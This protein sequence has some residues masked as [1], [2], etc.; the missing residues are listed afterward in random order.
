METAAAN[1]ATVRVRGQLAGARPDPGHQAQRCGRS[2]VRLRPRQRGVRRPEPTT[3][4]RSRGW[5]WATEHGAPAGPAETTRRRLYQDGGGARRGPW[6][7]SGPPRRRPG[8]E[9]VH[10]H[11]TAARCVRRRAAIAADGQ[12]P[13]GAEAQERDGEAESSTPWRWASHS[14]V[15][16]V[17]GR[18]RPRSAN[19]RQARPPCRRTRRC[20][21]TVLLDPGASA[22]P[23]SA[24]QP[25]PRS[26][27]SSARRRGHLL[28]K[29]GS[30]PKTGSAAF[31]RRRRPAHLACVSGSRPGSRS[32]RTGQEGQPDAALEGQLAAPPSRVVEHLLHVDARCRLVASG[33][34]RTASASLSAVELDEL[35]RSSVT[36]SDARRS[37]DALRLSSSS[38]A[39]NPRSPRAT[40]APAC[41]PQRWS[42]EP[43][44]RDHDG[45]RRDARPPALRR[46]G[47]KTGD[48]LPEDRDAAPRLLQRAARRP[49]RARR[50]RGGR[51]RSAHADAHARSTSGARH[52]PRRGARSPAGVHSGRTLDSVL[53]A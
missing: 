46:L 18:S 11:L 40:L 21:A 32:A 31:R 43:A 13:L 23:L 52:P 48:R 45:Q 7:G 35:I 20:E 30:I 41:S 27:R 39:P 37:G 51:R 33:A 49:G 25:E 2:G 5:R 24:A 10:L 19:L 44:G 4:P 6:E 22:R 17:A 28:V 29:R 42:G 9:S 3:T 53:S 14:T 15:A 1:D 8:A 50:L 12:Q 26:S 16:S 47:L 36:S 38:W 34:G